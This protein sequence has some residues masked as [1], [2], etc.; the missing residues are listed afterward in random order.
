[1]PPLGPR[2]VTKLS[3]KPTNIKQ[4]IRELAFYYRNYKKMF[5]VAVILSL[6]GGIAATSA[7]LLNGY[8]YSEFII[9]SAVITQSHATG[10]PIPPIDYTTFGLVSF[11]W[12]CV[13]L[14][15][16][17]LISN[18]FNWLESYLLLKMSEGG[19][20]TLRDA[21]FTKLN[22]MPISYFDRTPSGDIM[23]RTINDVDNI[24]QALSQ[25]LGSIFY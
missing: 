6:I 10:S 1:M 13:G 14:L 22:K 12:L 7:I 15:T 25:Y 8:I 21:V 5:I 9:P 4:T 18:G 23:S 24:G 2:A 11:I 3:S 19:S 17:Y 20:Y 16:V